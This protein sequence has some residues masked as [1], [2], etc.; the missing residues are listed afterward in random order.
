[1]DT[2]YSNVNL[3]TST[4]NQLYPLKQQKYKLSSFQ[5]EKKFRWKA[6]VVPK[7]AVTILGGNL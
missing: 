7:M 3:S 6:I 4:T 1:M 2:F 5:E